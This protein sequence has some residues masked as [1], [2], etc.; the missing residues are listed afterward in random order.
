MYS[1]VLI[2][3]V[4]ISF[5]S[6]AHLLCGSQYNSSTFFMWKYICIFLETDI[7]KLNHDHGFN[8]YIC[9]QLHFPIKHFLCLYMLA[10]QYY[11]LAQNAIFMH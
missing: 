2:T 5:Y 3:F 9:Q 11:K 7:A 6:V 1:H 4:S 8:V 10:F